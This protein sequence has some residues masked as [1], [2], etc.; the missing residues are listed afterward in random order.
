M[1]RNLAPGEKKNTVI[2]LGIVVGNKG[3]GKPE[4]LNERYA[5]FIFGITLGD[6]WFQKFKYR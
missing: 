3:N 5:N 4:Q 1:Y 6:Q 2:N